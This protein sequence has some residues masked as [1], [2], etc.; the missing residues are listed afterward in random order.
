[1]TIAI[2]VYCTGFAFFLC[3]LYVSIIDPDDKVGFIDWLTVIFWPFVF[4][5]SIATFIYSEIKRK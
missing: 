1:M 4:L 3:M 5:F 2:T